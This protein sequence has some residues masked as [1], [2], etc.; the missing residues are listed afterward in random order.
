ML[1]KTYPIGHL[2]NR[3]LSDYPQFVT[4]IAQVRRAA[5]Q[6]NLQNNRI[7]KA[8]YS[9]IA[10]ACEEVSIEAKTLFSDCSFYW[11]AGVSALNVV[12]H[13][14]CERSMVD[15]CLVTLNQ[16]TAD[17][18]A[19]ANESVVFNELTEVLSAVDVIVDALNVKADQFANIVKCGRLGLQDA[20]PVFVGTEIRSYAQAI[21]DAAK[22]IAR[23]QLKWSVSHFGSG[24]L[25]T[26]FAIESGF[27]DCA[28][29]SFNELE[30]RC[31][32]RSKEPFYALNQSGKFLSTHNALVELAFAVWRLSHDLEFLSSG[33]RGGI[34]ELILPAIAPGSS[35]MPG[36]INPTAAEL[37]CATSDQ[38][39]ADQ[40]ALMSA[41]H[42]SWG[43]KGSISLLPL[44]ILMEDA[45]LLART[46]RVITE[47]VIE[48]LKANEQH[49]VKQAENSLALGLILRGVADLVDVQKVM[50]TAREHRITIKEAALRLNVVT[51]EQA[52]DL[53]DV[54]KLAG[55]ENG[56]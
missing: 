20:T 3:T 40:D 30:G 21:E 23:E 16:A 10:Q 45:G 46:C 6:A 17:C 2:G 8:Q 28:T 26:G 27:G 32:K 47:K 14:I 44:K 33:P 43:A 24:D 13:M 1:E 52:A 31:Y 19:T 35:I 56:V 11:G 18:I 9:A 50:Q 42:R 48:G 49:S 7:T 51:P 22:S 41:I 12:T 54:Q 15:K 55:I 29:E 38:V 36:K 25:G 4:A 5:A 53:F 37:A 34:R 39:L